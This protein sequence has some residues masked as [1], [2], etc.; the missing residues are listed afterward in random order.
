MTVRGWGNKTIAE[1]QILCD[2]LWRALS[3]EEKAKYKHE[4]KRAKRMELDRAVKERQAQELMEKQATELRRKQAEDLRKKQDLSTQALRMARGFMLL[5]KKTKIVLLEM[6]TPSLAFVA[7]EIELDRV[8][9]HLEKTPR[10]RIEESEVRKGSLGFCSYSKDGLMYRCE[11]LSS[12]RKKVN[13][14]F[15]L[16]SNYF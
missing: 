4:K 14:N 6:I 2:P 7:P 13:R 15:S 8:Q 1:L 16:L 3:K 12:D 9:K 11:V 5:K 10:T